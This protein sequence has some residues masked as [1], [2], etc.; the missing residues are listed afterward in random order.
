MEHRPLLEP[1]GSATV[2]L[3]PL[4]P[5]HWSHLAP[6]DVITMYEGRPVAGTATLIE[7][8]PPAPITRT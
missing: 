1:G 3:A 8:A 2:R 6:G 5:E 4:A 7:I